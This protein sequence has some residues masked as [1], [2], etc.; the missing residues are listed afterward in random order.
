MMNRL[1]NFYL[2]CGRNDALK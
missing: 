1:W 2:Y